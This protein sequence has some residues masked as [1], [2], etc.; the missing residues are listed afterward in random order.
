LRHFLPFGVVDQHFYAGQ[1]PL[2]N[3]SFGLLLSAFAQRAPAASASGL[4]GALSALLVRHQPVLQP[5]Y[6][7]STH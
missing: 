7:V 3:F 4:A 2:N 5:A 1:P 6:D